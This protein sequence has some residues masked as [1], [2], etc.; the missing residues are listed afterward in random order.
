[1][2]KIIS[3]EDAKKQELETYERIS[4]MLQSEDATIE[5]FCCNGAAQTTTYRA[6]NAPTLTKKDAGF[7]AYRAHVEHMKKQ[8][9]NDATMGYCKEN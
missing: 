3:I 4:E 9:M 2:T 1:M 6:M 5:V 8:L 7:L